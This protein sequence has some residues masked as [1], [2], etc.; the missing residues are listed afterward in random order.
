M[1][2]IAWYSFGMTHDDI[3]LAQLSL[4]GQLIRLLTVRLDC[5]AC[6][7]CVGCMVQGHSAGMCKQCP[8]TKL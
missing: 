8:S 4:D 5:V 2:K 3:L 6:S 1:A 7:F